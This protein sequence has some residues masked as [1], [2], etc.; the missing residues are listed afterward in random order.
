MNKELVIV[1]VKNAIPG[2]VKTRL[3][4]TIGNQAAFK[5]YKELIKITEKTLENL[6]T[7][8]VR[9]YF[10]DFIVNSEWTNYH[11]HTQKGEN[12]G[13]RME[14]A[15]NDGF[16]NGYNRIVLIGSDLPDITAKHIESGLSLLNKYDTV[17][18]P[19]IDGGYYLIGMRNMHKMAFKNKPWSQP[20]L[21]SKT[22]NQLTKNNITFSTLDTLNDIDTFEDLKNSNFYKSNKVLQEKIKNSHD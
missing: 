9:I 8:D 3:A 21:L 6:T 20:N 10:S 17:F 4:K 2:K 13:D 16:N 14:N 19:A 11:K 5:V 1:F 12:L 18:G 22:L 7:A 15:F